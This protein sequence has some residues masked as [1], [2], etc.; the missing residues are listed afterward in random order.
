MLIKRNVPDTF[1]EMLDMVEEA[2]CWGV[3]VEVG[4]GHGNQGWIAGAR[5]RKCYVLVRVERKGV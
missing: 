1:D 2:P 5:D 3:G 4:S